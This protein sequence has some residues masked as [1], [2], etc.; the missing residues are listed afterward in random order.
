MI[1]SCTGDLLQ[2]DTEALVNAVNCVGVMG[3]GIALQ[4]KRTYPANFAAY[5]AACKQGDV[6]TGRMFVF[7]TNASTRP[8]YIVNFPT[9]DDWRGKSR[10][11]YIDTGLVALVDAI[12]HYTIRSIAI[13]PLGS[14]LG[15]LDWNVVR[16]RIERAL[17]PL[18]DV[19]VRIYEPISIRN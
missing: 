9:K 19:D 5:A 13:P 15:G 12:H 11:E 4:F 16:Q 1:C 14:G 2:S 3:R 18:T 7:A 17:A 6:Q 8:K 10:L